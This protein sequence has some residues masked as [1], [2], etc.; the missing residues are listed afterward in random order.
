MRKAKQNVVIC[1]HNKNGLKLVSS[2]IIPAILKEMR[3]DLVDLDVASV[4][5]ILSPNDILVQYSLSKLINTLYKHGWFVINNSTNKNT[6][7]MFGKWDAS[8]GPATSSFETV[9]NV[10]CIMKTMNILCIDNM[11]IANTNNSSGNV[12]SYLYRDVFV[13]IYI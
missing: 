11:S 13:I 8:T 10:Y 2:K 9:L 3:V 1:S 7:V 6:N 12:P 4:T 5:T